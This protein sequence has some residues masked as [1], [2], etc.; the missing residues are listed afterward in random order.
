M[1]IP[2]RRFIVSNIL[3]LII[4]CLVYLLS[5][6]GD[7]EAAITDVYSEAKYKGEVNTNGSI[8]LMILI[9]DDI[10]EVVAIEKIAVEKS[11]QVSYMLSCDLIINHQEK[12]EELIINGYGIGLYCDNEEN[13]FRAIGILKSHYQNDILYVEKNQKIDKDMFSN[14]LTVVVYSIDANI[15]Y[16]KFSDNFTSYIEEGTFVIVENHDESS[17][18][19]IVDAIIS[20]GFKIRSISEMLK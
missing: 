2:S 15:A 5:F 10:D 14:R 16:E 8:G 6:N 1:K 9:N 17:M 18:L 11:M 12:V 13:L 19:K 7:V 4:I 3:V 20:S